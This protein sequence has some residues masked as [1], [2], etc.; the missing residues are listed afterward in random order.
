MNKIRILQD[1]IELEEQDTALDIE[2]TTPVSP[3]DVFKIK[4]TVNQ[5]THLELYQDSQEESKMD[6]VFDIADHVSFQVL[7]IHKNDK[8]KIQNEYRLCA[9]SDVV[10]T[11]FYD[12]KQ[13]K[14]LDLIQLNGEYASIKYCLKTIAK[15]KE[16]FDMVTYHNAA[17]TKSE[18]V[19]NGLNIEE[20]SIDFQVTSIVYQGIKDC[21]LNQNNRIITM[22]HHKC[23]IEPILLI[24]EQDVI[25]N[26]SAYIGQFNQQQLF[27][28]MSRGIP[29]DKAL[30]LLIKGF[31]LE[32]VPKIDSI[33]KIIEQYWR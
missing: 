2:T 16:R 4:I 18:I 25:A 33:L 24:E 12:C 28:L 21:T 26:H 17:H 29:K 27:Y 32:S 5:S 3:F 30:Q 13:V 10:V 31:L 6:I 14:E 22:N 1:Q 15:E 8:L 23:N 7:E 19:N 9:Y 20:G 11:K